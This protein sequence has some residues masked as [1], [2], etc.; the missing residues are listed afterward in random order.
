MNPPTIW[1][2]TLRAALTLALQARLYR[3]PDPW[4]RTTRALLESVTDQY[5][6]IDA[7]Q[8]Q[9]F[10]GDLA[11]Y[12][13]YRLAQQAADTAPRH[14][15]GGAEVDRKTQKRQEAEARQ[16]LSEYEKP[17]LKRLDRAGARAPR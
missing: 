15:A 3:Q 1:T 11:D 4:C 16:R 13:A 6:L 7:G 8:V 10:D 12:C 14:A 2:W 17:L 5:W 9:P